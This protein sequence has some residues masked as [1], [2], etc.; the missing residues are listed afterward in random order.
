MICPPTYGMY[1][2][3]AVI[4]GAGVVEVPLIKENDFSLDITAI[5]QKWQPGI[6]LIFLCSPNNP[7][8]NLLSATDIL[9]LCQQLAGKAIIVVDEAYMEFSAGESLINYLA[10]YSNLVVLRTLSKAYGLAGIRCGATIANPV[11]IQ[12]LRKIIAPYPIAQPIID[13][14]RQR[15]TVPHPGEQVKIINEEK[16]KL[17][18]FLARLAFVKK[19]WPS[20]ANFLLFEVADVKKVMAVCLSQGIVLRDRSSEYNLSH[21]LRVTIGMPVENKILRKALSDV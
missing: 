19:V 8:G 2:V 3:A 7:T 10:D 9:S 20:H 6:K 13:I 14:C 21:C 5:L 16:E 4:Q 15:L 1:K 17:A 11:I 18:A 12:L